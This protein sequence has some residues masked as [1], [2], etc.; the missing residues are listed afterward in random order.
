MKYLKLGENDNLDTLGRNFS[1]LEVSQD[2][3][4]ALSKPAENIITVDRRDCFKMI[5]FYNSAN[6]IQT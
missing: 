4:K 2:S 1:K 6:K 5:K 3:L